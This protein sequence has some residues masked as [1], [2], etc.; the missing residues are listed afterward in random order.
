MSSS[1]DFV[2][3]RLDFDCDEGVVLSLEEAQRPRTVVKYAA[4]PGLACRSRRVQETYGTNPCEH[5]TEDSATERSMY[6]TAF[7]HAAG[8]DQATRLPKFWHNRSDN[9]LSDCLG[10]AFD[11]RTEAQDQFKSFTVQFVPR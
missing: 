3:K 1:N 10:S 2:R 6:Q 5:M 9:M 7:P 8:G 4:V 11:S